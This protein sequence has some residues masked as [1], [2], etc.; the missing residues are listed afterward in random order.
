MTHDKYTNWQ[1]NW[2]KNTKNVYN[3]YYGIEENQKEKKNDIHKHDFHSK[4]SHWM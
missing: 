2:K 1:E 4:Y 3:N